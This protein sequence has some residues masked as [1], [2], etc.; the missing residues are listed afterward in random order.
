M[1]KKLLAGIFALTLLV[2]AGYGVNESMKNDAVLNDLALTN[3]EALAL[4]ESGN[5]FC[6]YYCSSWPFTYCYIQMS[7]IYVYCA[8]HFPK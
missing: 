1:K 7:T 5:L 4:P 6:N 3:V 2:A 8:E